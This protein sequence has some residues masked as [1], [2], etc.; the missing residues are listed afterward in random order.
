[1]LPTMYPYDL[2]G[3]T[4]LWEKF[5]REGTLSLGLLDPAIARS[6]VRC[7]DAGLDPQAV[8]RSVRSTPGELEQQRQE[9]FDLIAVAQPLME[10]I[11][12][13]AG[14]LGI[15]V[16]LTSQHRIVLESLGDRWLRDTLYAH[17]SLKFGLVSGIGVN[18]CYER[19]TECDERTGR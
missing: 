17:S 6:W 8:P 7:R 18:F 2:Q 16:Y 3:L 10:D 19:E 9:H 12:Q 1:M 15:V 5:V 13:F 14:E 4:L 11:Y